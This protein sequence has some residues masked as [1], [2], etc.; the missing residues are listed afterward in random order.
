M[1]DKEE[2]TPHASGAGRVQVPASRADVLE[3]ID[4]AFLDFIE[5]LHSAVH[6]LDGSDPNDVQLALKA[7][8]R[9]GV[10][11]KE[12][13][14]MLFASRATLSRWTSGEI[15]PRR[16]VRNGIISE[17]QKF[18]DRLGKAA[19]DNPDEVQPL[20][21]NSR[22]GPRRE[23]AVALTGPVTTEKMR[24]PTRPSATDKQVR[25]LGRSLD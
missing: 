14:A 21:E 19:R 17:L 10:S 13:S 15:L 23:D 4:C 25:G 24:E 5:K 6:S 12:L 20:T 16:A 2:V 22:P 1:S 9:T 8:L 11:Q 18:V 3:I 7:V